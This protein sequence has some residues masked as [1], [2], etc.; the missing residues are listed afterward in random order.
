MMGK[1]QIQAL[2]TFLGSTA[3]FLPQESGEDRHHFFAEAYP[4]LVEL[5]EEAKA[6]VAK[7]GMTELV[8]ATI[9]D[10]MTMVKE[11]RRRKEAQ[12]M[13]FATSSALSERSGTW[14]EMRRTYT[15]SSDPSIS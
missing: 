13:L 3:V 1:K 11:G 15:A 4:C 5:Y 2:E 9:R 8:E 12:D 14:D 6:D 10:C 7:L